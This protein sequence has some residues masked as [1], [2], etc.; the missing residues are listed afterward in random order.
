MCI[1]IYIYIYTVGTHDLG[2]ANRGPGA[3]VDADHD[4]EGALPGLHYTSLM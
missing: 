4:P 3:A 2:A 1:S